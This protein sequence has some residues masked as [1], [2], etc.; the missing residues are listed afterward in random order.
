MY[1]LNKDAI[2][3]LPNFYCELG[4]RELYSLEE[5]KDIAKNF[6][7]E[8]YDFNS[9]LKE[10][11]KNVDNCKDV[12]GVQTYLCNSILKGFSFKIKS[13]LSKLSKNQNK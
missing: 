13:N 6:M 3:N 5:A 12:L 4:I 11:L 7:L 8:R 1:N 10:F 2:T 9:K